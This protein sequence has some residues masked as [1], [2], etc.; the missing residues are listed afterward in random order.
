VEKDEKI[1]IPIYSLH[2]D[3][4][5]FKDPEVFDPERFS[6]EENAK[7]PK[8]TYLPFGDGPRICIGMPVKRKRFKLRNNIAF[9]IDRFFFVSLIGKRFVELQMKMALAEILTKFEVE[10][11]EK[12]VVPLSLTKMV[13]FL[14]PDHDIWLKFVNIN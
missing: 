4:K 10:P 13:I 8:G 11:C 7:R 1:M 5:Y 6:P 12:T 3:P 14:T 2:H 9:G